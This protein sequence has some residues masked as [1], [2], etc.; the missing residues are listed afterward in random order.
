[1][2]HRLLMPS[3]FALYFNWTSSKSP[4]STYA[5]STSHAF[6]L[7]LI[8]QLD[9]LQV[10]FVHVCP[11]DFSDLRASPYTSTGPPPSLL[12][13]RMPH[14]LLRPSSFALYFNWTSSKSP[15]STYAPSTS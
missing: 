13:P 10:S 1:M 3:S 8:L 2:P 9:L 7:R 11:I 4:S 5:P 15:S 6:E 12:R 14:R